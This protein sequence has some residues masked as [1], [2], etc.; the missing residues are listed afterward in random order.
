MKNDSKA[1]MIFNISTEGPYEVVKTK[2][3]SEEM[4]PLSKKPGLKTIQQT[5]ETMFNLQPNT[6]VQLTT[7]FITPDQSNKDEWPD[8]IHVEQKGRINVAFAN[9]KSQSFDLL[10]KLTR[11]QLRLQPSKNALAQ[12]E[13]D[14]GAVNTDHSRTITFFLSNLTGAAAHWTL[15]YV[16][17]PVRQTLGY[18]TKTKLE[19]ENIASTDDP[20]VFSFSVTGG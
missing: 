14:L 3:N 16:K 1:N 6:I 13:L 9:G 5:A 19:N 10:G 7:V 15:N 17:F 2:T 18:K 8:I 12:D 20:D 11:P 4:H